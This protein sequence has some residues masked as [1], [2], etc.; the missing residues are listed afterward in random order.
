MIPANVVAAF[1]RRILNVHP[2]LLPAFGGEGMYGHHVHDAVL[3][4]GASVSG[5]TVHFV[6]EEYDTGAI[7]AQWPV[8]VHHDDTSESLSARVLSAEH[9]LYPAVAD[10]LARAI[11]TDTEMPT[12]CPPADA[13]V[14][15]PWDRDGFADA[16]RR[17]FSDD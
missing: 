16:M 4:A 17:G 9:M 2:A 6:D 5:P 1:P 12:F 13:F 15:G 14:G 7:I 3:R 8:P 10:R 11:A